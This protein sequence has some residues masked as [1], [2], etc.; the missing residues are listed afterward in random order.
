MCECAQLCPTLWNPMVCNPPVS[1]VHGI[2][3]ARML[4]WVAISFS[5]GSSWPRDRTHV[6]CIGRQ[7]LWPT[8]YFYCFESFA[9]NCCSPYKDICICNLA[10]QSLW[11]CS[12]CVYGRGHPP[13]VTMLKWRNNVT[14]DLGH[15]SEL[16]CSP[17]ILPRG[18]GG[19]A[20]HSQLEL[21]DL[22]C[23]EGS[24]RY[25]RRTAFLGRK[26]RGLLFEWVLK[27]TVLEAF[28]YMMWFNFQQ[29][30]YCS[31]L[32]RYRGEA[33]GNEIICQW[34]QVPD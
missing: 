21:K 14:S 34:F 13:V 2:F 10:Y 20:G 26:G 25:R 29:R 3:Q 24:D 7:I 12:V 16:E 11:Y 30:K 8:Q 18:E 6:S 27:S 19:F 15:G 9:C 28:T 23:S 5:E 1:S 22:P 32:F 31:F 17:Q 33:H 4:E